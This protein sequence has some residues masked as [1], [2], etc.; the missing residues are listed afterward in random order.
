M[1]STGLLGGAVLACAWAE[2]CFESMSVLKHLG[3][4]QATS[5]KE[6]GKFHPHKFRMLA[7]K[8]GSKKDNTQIT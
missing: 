1:I 6:I 4:P 3:A 8:Q 2:Y 7:T 5:T